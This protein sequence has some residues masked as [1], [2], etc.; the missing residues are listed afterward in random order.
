[1]TI[2]IRPIAQ[3]QMG[4]TARFEHAKQ[5]LTALHRGWFRPTRAVRYDVYAAIPVHRFYQNRQQSDCGES[6]A[7]AG[8][9]GRCLHDLD[10]R[11]EMTE[12]DSGDRQPQLAGLRDETTDAGTSSISF[13]NMRQCDVRYLRR[14]VEQDPVGNGH[15]HRDMGS[16][17][18][19][20]SASSRSSVV[21]AF[22]R[23]VLT[24]LRQTP[25]LFRSTARFITLDEAGCC[26]DCGY[27]QAPD[28][29]GGAPRI[30]P[31]AMSPDATGGRANN[32]DADHSALVNSIVANRRPPTIC[33]GRCDNP[34]TAVAMA[35]NPYVPTNNAAIDALNDIYYVS[36]GSGGDRG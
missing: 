5:G 4:G 12:G 30:P 1:M 23:K 19:G 34:S 36:H 26:S 10:P 27:I 29:V 28:F 35:A 25:N 13:D 6:H 33:N 20:Q 2:T 11:V 8:Q 15:G 9:P 31:P 17:N 32:A 18:D 14:L 24:P 3:Q 21:E 7:T 22:L 16:L